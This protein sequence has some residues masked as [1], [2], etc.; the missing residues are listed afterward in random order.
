MCFACYRSERVKCE[1]L[2]VN[3][4]T[5]LEKNDARLVSNGLEICVF[6]QVIQIERIRIP[7]R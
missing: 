7:G 3:K 5:Y 4:K 1:L 2:L 6:L